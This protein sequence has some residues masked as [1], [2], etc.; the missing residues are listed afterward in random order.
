MQLADARRSP[1][2]LQVGLARVERLD[3]RAEETA[4]LE[5]GSRGQ[6]AYQWQANARVQPPQGTRRA[7]LRDTEL[8]HSD[9]AAGLD[10]AR[11]LAHRRRWIVDIAQQVGERE[12]VEVTVGKRQLLGVRTEASDPLPQD[13]VVRHPGA[14]PGKHLLAL[15]ERDHLAAA[16]ANELRCHEPCARCDVQNP[17]AW[18]WIDRPNQCP[19]P[20]GVLAEAEHRAHPVIATRQAGKKI[21]SMTLARGQGAVGGR[22]HY[23]L[24]RTRLRAQAIPPVR[25]NSSSVAYSHRH[26]RA[27]LEQRQPIGRHGRR[28]RDSRFLGASIPTILLIRHAQASFGGS[29]YDILSERG[30][31]QVGALVVGL[32]RRGVAADRVIVG[33]LR[34]QIDTAAPCA[35]A[36]RRELTVDDRWNEYDDRDIISHYGGVLAG[37]D[38]QPGDNPLSS[39]EFQQLLNGAL[40]QWIAAGADG[41]CRESW[42]QFLGRVKAALAD[43]AA[44]LG[45]GRTALVISSGGAIA[46]LS[47]AL[48]RLPPESM[49]TF[50]HVSVNT[51][52]T[53]LAVGCGGTTLITS[54]DHAH[55]EEAGAALI[56]YR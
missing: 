36:L 53:K 37:L 52:I 20:T 10:H 49:I 8:D 21:E 54:N 1:L 33:S 11:Q 16:A 31:E 39:R 14:R 40:T 5:P 48:Q 50:N 42:P 12:R 27:G 6:A 29:D 3:A 47:A 38:R 4:H 9:P 43:L 46:A 28:R 55:L 56:T 45:K 22:C 35:A 32:Q 17:L 2:R 15:I 41:R 30:Q 13:S 18:A 19:A 51:A 24:K 26:G 34:R 25:T 23:R 7:R 44:G